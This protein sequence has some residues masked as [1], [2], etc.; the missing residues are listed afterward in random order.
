MN[1]ITYVR[2]AV[3]RGFGRGAKEL[4]CPTANVQGA[5]SIDIPTGIYCGLVQLIINN[6]KQIQPVPGFEREFQETVQRLPYISPVRGMVSS[7]G[8]NPHY[9]N[10]ER[11]L[12]VHILDDFKF[13]FYGA[14]LRV[15]ICKKMRDEEKYNSLEELKS[16]IANDVQNAKNEVQNFQKHAVNSEYFLDVNTINNNN[17]NHHNEN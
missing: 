11:T 13:D 16:A 5:E 15:L 1:Q 17:S 10:K 2:N 12:E 3:I 8:Y 7:C 6:E 14:E 9:G 4:G